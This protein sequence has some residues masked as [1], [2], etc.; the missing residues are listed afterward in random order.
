MHIIWRLVA[1]LWQKE[2]AVIPAREC[3]R[4]IGR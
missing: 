2:D 3:D 4:L 1:S